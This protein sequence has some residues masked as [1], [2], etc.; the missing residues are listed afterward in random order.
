M[1]KAENPVHRIEALDLIRGIAICGLVPINILDFASSEDWYFAPANLK[2]SEIWLWAFLSTFGFGKF[3]SLFSIL[4]GASMILQ[5]NKIEQLGL[6]VVKSYLPR[7]GW[8][9]FFG[10]LHAYLIWYGD[11]LVGYAIT[12]FVVLWFR[13]LSARTLG[14]VGWGV[15]FF[16][17][18]FW[19]ILLWMIFMAGF[20]DEIESALTETEADQGTFWDL[21][22]FS[23]SWIEQMPLRATFAVLTQLFGIPFVILPSCGSL[24][25]IGM[26]L[27]KN[28][29]F[30]YR[31]KKNSYRISL[32]IG[33]AV[34]IG[35][36]LVGVLLS[37]RDGWNYASLIKH[38]PFGLLATPFLA[39]A[40]ATTLVIWAQSSLLGW[41]QPG[42]KALGRM[43]FSNYIGQSL[44]FSLIFYGHGLGMRG[45]LSL[46]E[47][48]MICPLVWIF[49]ITISSIWLRYFRTGPL[50]G[51]WRRLASSS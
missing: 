47:V 7:L 29:F 20:G 50:E 16:L 12:G 46:S 27:Y 36:G 25:L 11:I 2:D 23:G 31:W 6:P 4:F 22:T 9:W 28:G 43:A 10:M 45:Q 39:F 49:Q 33:F 8:L 44:I 21:A 15:H 38:A 30:E 17:A 18:L 19:S 40:Y 48:V 13:N 35:L 37:Y 51:I 14:I 1:I 41:L 5:T 42:I 32:A 34:G 3:V 26:S 24:M